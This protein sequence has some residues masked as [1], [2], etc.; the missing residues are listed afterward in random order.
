MDNTKIAT[1]KK[2]LEDAQSSLA[3]ASSILAEIS[4]AKIE[5]APVSMPVQSAPITS[6]E[7][8][9]SDDKVVEGVFDGQNMIDA[10]GKKYPVPANY[11]S[12]SKLVAGDILKLSIQADG[13]FLYKQ[14]GPVD[15]KNVIGILN[16]EGSQFYV[17]VA[18]KRY[19]VLLASVT[20]FKAAAGD[21][22]TIIVP[23]NEDSDW[24]CIEN[25]L[26]K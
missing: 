10:E 6:S 22:V 9:S 24:A 4:G 18:D 25:V 11:A 21:Q 3:S 12:K 2:L 20:Y 26:G 23:A 19:N 13:R 16:Q 8:E 1:V 17:Q 15:R 5:A 7:P 14:I